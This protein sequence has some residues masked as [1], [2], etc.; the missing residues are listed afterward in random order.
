MGWTWKRLLRSFC[1]TNLKANRNA[2]SLSVPTKKL[3]RLA[4]GRVMSLSVDMLDVVIGA[5]RR[6]HPGYIALE[7]HEGD[8]FDSDR[9]D[10]SVFAWVRI[11]S[12]MRGG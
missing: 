3:N 9:R 6:N 7:L 10:L 5:L 12:K 4:R 1:G 11:S 8:V 2:A